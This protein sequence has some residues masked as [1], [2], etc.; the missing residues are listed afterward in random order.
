MLEEVEP[1]GSGSVSGGMVPA[2]LPRLLPLPADL[3]LQ[4][5][6]GQQTNYDSY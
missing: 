5:C 2:E 4:S 1:K 6:D 3:L